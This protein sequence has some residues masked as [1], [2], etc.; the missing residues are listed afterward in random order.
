MTFKE[1]EIREAERKAMAEVRRWKR[2][3]TKEWK[4]LPPDKR[5]EYFKKQAE[6]LRAQGFDIVTSLET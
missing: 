5:M 2:E 1:K 4:S 6:D 3:A